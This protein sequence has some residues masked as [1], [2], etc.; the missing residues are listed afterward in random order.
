M[1]FSSGLGQ[2]KG[3]AN[4][5]LL[6]LDRGYYHYH[7]TLRPIASELFNSH[8]IS[9][10]LITFRVDQFHCP[11]RSKIDL[12]D[13]VE[14]QY[15]FCKEH[16]GFENSIDNLFRSQNLFYKSLKP[17][18][19]LVRRFK[20]HLNWRYRAE[21]I[22]NCYKPI[23]IITHKTNREEIPYLLGKSKYRNIPTFAVN[24]NTDGLY[25]PFIF[26]ALRRFQ[27]KK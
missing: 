21:E 18:F 12:D 9:S 17:I 14:L 25:R 22:L 26:D 3:S 19:Y 6:L 23:A 13:F 7:D 27:F 1:S 4:Y 10:K 8:G 16:Q 5:V 20:H 2:K 24:S 11:H 15:N